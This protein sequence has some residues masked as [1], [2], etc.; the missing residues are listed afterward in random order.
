MAWKEESPLFLIRT[1]QG[2]PVFKKKGLSRHLFWRSILFFG[3]LFLLWINPE[4]A[5]A[6]EER[7]S[8]EECVQSALEHHPGAREARAGV[9]EALGRLGLAKTGDALT[10]DMNLDYARERGFHDAESDNSYNSSAVLAKP[11]F[12]WGRTKT[13]ISMALE[14]LAISQ[15]EEYRALEEIVYNVEKA[16]YGL[17]ESQRDAQVARE[18]LERYEEHLH[19]AKAFYEVGSNPYFDVTAAEVEAST[20][21]IALIRG[22][23]A[24]R[25]ARTVLYNAMGRPASVDVGIEDNSDFEEIDIPFREVL[26]VAFTFRSDLKAASKRVVQG[27]QEILLL[28]RENAPLLSARGAYRLGGTSPGEEDAWNLEM[29]LSIPLY[30]GG[31]TREKIQIARGTLEKKK[32]QEILLRQKI[33]LEVE[34]AWLSLLEAEESIRVAALAKRQAEE[35]LALATERYDVGMGS[36]IEVTDA[37]ESMSDAARDY[38]RALYT[39]SMARAELRYATGRSLLAYGGNFSETFEEAR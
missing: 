34:Q 16:Y 27:S 31:V 28:A 37:N 30:D 1:L 22:D 35:K 39:Y 10:F 19:R 33:V 36:P 18:T 29:V 15:L 17:L 7:L 32:A 26:D 6:R 5:F 23:S 9:E 12:D 20:A 14:G 4:G 13:E 3:F 2:C 25:K 38:N 24:V 21:R 11:L 8:L